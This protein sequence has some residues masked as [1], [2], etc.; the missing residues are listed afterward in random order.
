M[1]PSR[2]APAVGRL[3]KAASGALAAAGAKLAGEHGPELIV[4]PAAV[5][6]TPPPQVSAA[7]ADELRSAYLSAKDA[8]DAAKGK[9]QAEMGLSDVLLIAETGELLAENPATESSVFDKTRFRA[10]HP[11]VPLDDYMKPRTQR[12]F[13]VLA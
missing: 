11:E 9:I 5:A 3:A 13:R 6:V 10:E 4:P 12:R 1:A 8:L 2:T 7:R